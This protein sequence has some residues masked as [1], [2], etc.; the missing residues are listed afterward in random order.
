VHPRREEPDRS[1]AADPAPDEL[2]VGRVRRPGRRGRA[3]VARLL[4]PAAR[5]GPLGLRFLRL[6]EPRLDRELV[7]AQPRLGGRVS[8]VEREADRDRLVRRERDVVGL[9]FDRVAV[10]DEGDRLVRVADP[11]VRVPVARVRDL[12][13]AVD[14]AGRP[15]VDALEG[16][17]SDVRVRRRDIDRDLVVVIS[18]GVLPVRAVGRLDREVAVREG[19]GR[20]VDH[21]RARG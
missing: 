16:G 18:V 14:P 13:D 7:G 8:G 11:D 9:A 3:A 1:P 12:E 10:G 4:G 15:D 6:R 2:A 20:A 19:V 21:R 5:R 17:I